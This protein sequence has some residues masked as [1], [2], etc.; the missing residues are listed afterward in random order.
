[1]S[2]SKILKY[3]AIGVVGFVVA[4]EIYYKLVE[5]VKE[6]LGMPDENREIY[7]SFCTQ[8]QCALR[9]NYE[10]SYLVRQMSF[11]R[12]D[13]LFI[14]EVIEN[15]IKS[16]KRQV[17]VA[18]YIFTNR[19][20]CEALKDIQQRRGVKVYVIVDQSMESASG[21]QVQFMQ[22]C[23]LNVKI[24]S[25]VTMHHKFCLID[26]PYSREMEIFSSN[27]NVNVGTTADNFERIVL[28]KQGLLITGSLNW[29]REALSSNAENFIV[30]SERKLINDY[31]KFFFDCW[32]E[33]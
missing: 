10:K 28:P 22:K 33:A 20:L 8:G 30:T 21:S 25:R 17:H 29:T 15:L 19:V 16:A 11:E 1:M 9:K 2:L 23:G 14:T 24:Y 18:M 26:A 13:S 5:M 12:E 32:N 4:G 31:Q 6:K 3:T 27:Q 7:E